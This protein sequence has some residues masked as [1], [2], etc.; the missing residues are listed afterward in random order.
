M[1][2]FDQIWESSRTSA[3]SRVY[4]TVLWA[5]VGLRI[6]LSLFRT[7]WIRRASKIITIL[8]LTVVATEYAP[9]EF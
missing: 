8:A 5:G 3:W 4:P 6:A 1:E 2:T 7:G 9:R